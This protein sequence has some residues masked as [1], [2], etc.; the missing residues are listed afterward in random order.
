MWEH[1]MVGQVEHCINRYSEITGIPKK[2]IQTYPAPCVGDEVLKGADWDARGELSETAIKVVM[3][4][5]Y[6]ARL[7]RAECYHSC[8]FL[9]R[10]LSKCAPVC[11]RMLAR[12]I[13]YMTLT[14]IIACRRD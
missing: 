6:T 9:S 2:K 1:R 13:G 12:L 8:N 7:L 4:I 10:H 14:K 11:D 5:M 3:T